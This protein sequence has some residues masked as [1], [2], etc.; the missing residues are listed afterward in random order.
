M[1]A[2]HAGRPIDQFSVFH[3]WLDQFVRALCS[4]PEGDT[5]ARSPDAVR[6]EIVGR[7]DALV[8]ESRVG[9]AADKAREIRY[10]MAAFADEILIASRWP[11]R[12][13]WIDWLVEEKMFGSR[14]AGDRVFERIDA[15]LRSGEVQRR[16]MALPYLFA[17][18]LGFRGCA[19]GADGDQVLARTRRALFELAREREPDPAFGPAPDALDT[20][21]ARRVMFRPYETIAS[22]GVPVLLP[23]PYRW[24][25]RFVLAFVLLLAAGSAIWFV[26][27]DELRQHLQD[28]GNA[29]GGT[30]QALP[31]RRP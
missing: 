25:G 29:A 23:S 8:S 24:R 30:V 21:V 27:T 15:L 14:H 13:Q 17:L 3:T 26:Q 12:G 16:D 22:A 9:N 5:P 10:L 1:S 28:D 20:N 11:H 18:A 2:L 4:A 19:S 31:E 7:I 6:A